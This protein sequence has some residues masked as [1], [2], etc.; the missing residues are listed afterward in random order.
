M[1]EFKGSELTVMH[2][3]E[4]VGLSRSTA[5]HL[6]VEFKP[7]KDEIDIKNCIDRIHYREPSYDVRRI[8]NELIKS[9]FIAGKRFIK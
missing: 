2:Q 7:S 1:I 4:L 9:D 5:Y 8:W 3:C 6:P